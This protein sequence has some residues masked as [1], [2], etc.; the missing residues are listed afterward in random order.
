MLQSSFFDPVL[1]VDIHIVL[2]PTPAPV[3]T[4][5]PMPFIGMVFDPV[6]LAMGAAIGM[7]TGG[8]PGLVMVNS[9]PVTNAGTNVTN[10]L[11]MPH[12]PAPGVAF[13][14][15]LPGNDAE[16][17]FGS[18]DVKLAG[19]LGVRLGEIAM[20]CSDP[21]RLP[22][23]VVLA[24][25]KGMP[26]L[27][28]RPPVPDLEGIA[29]RLAMLGAMKLLKAAARGG[30]RLFR[31]LRTA[32]R[33][34]SKW[35]RISGAV[36]GV[37]DKIAPAR[38]RDRLKRAACFVTGHPV[39]VATGRVFTDSIDFGLPGSI[40]LVF[41]RVYSSSLSWRNGPLGYGWSHSL[42][43]QV[44]VEPNKVV[45]L[46]EDGR[47]VEFST[48]HLPDRVMRAGQAIFHPTERLTL[49][50]TGPFS[51]ALETD[52]G[53][54]REF[55]RVPGGPSRRAR[56]VR[57][58]NQTGDEVTWHYDEQGSLRTVRDCAGRRVGFEY[59][60]G[61]LVRVSVSSGAGQPWL[62]QRA[63]AYDGEGDLVEA[64]D[65]AGQSWRFEYV[66]HLL[67]REVNRNGLSFYFQY[68]GLG[69]AARCVRTW[70]DGGLLDRVIAYDVAN[71][72]TLVENSLGHVTVYE[73][74]DLGQVI[75]V[76]DALGQT[77]RYAYDPRTGQKC[78]EV[79]PL[80]AETLWEYDE[81]GH[82]TKRTRP[83]GIAVQMRFDSRGRLV[84]ARDPLEGEWSWAYDPKGRITQRVDP[85]GQRVRFEWDGSRL[86]GLHDAAGQYTR[87]EYDEQGNLT[88]LRTPDGTESLWRYDG[89]GQL[90]EG[91][92]AKGNV[93]KREYDLLGR[94]VRVCEPDGNVRILG[95]DPE[96]NITHVRDKHHEVLLAYQGL[97]RLRSRTES[98][99]TVSF[100]YDSEEQL[101]G[102][103]NEGG[104]AY[105]FEFDAA[106]AVKTER[107]F[108]G[109]V[110]QYVRDPA[111]R[112][113]KVLRPL[114]KVSEYA[115]DILG[116][117]TSVKHWDGI[118]TYR[119][120]ADGEF[121]EA[122][123][124]T[125]TVTFE[126]DALG[127]VTREQQG[128]DWVASEYDRLGRRVRVSSSKDFHQKIRRNAMGDVLELSVQFRESGVPADGPQ[129]HK[130]SAPGAGLESGQGFRVDF[131]RDELGF[132]LERMLPGGVRST[133]ERDRLGR[134]IRQEIWSPQGS[135]GARQYTWDVDD[136]L[137]M[138]VDS[139][140]GPMKYVHDS[141]GNLVAAVYSDGQTELRMP[142]A[143]GN[144][145]RTREQSDRRYGPT[146]QLLEA[147]GPRGVTRYEYD[148]EGNLVRKLEPD[149]REWRYEW[150]AS[151]MLVRV[152]RPDGQ[153][154]EFGYD[155]F[156]RRVWK[157]FQ[158]KTTR[159]I[160]DG[161]L[162]L[163]EWKEN[164]APGVSGLPAPTLRGV[165]DTVA[166]KRRQAELGE[167]PAQ[168]PP[169]EN[170][171][172]WVF[173]PGSFAPLAKFVDGE[174]FGIVTDHLGAPRAMFDG[175]GEKVWSAD[176]GVYGELLNL[177]GERDACPFRW[178]G[179]YEDAETGLYY[180]RHRYYAA[181]EGEYLSQDPLGLR[182]GLRLLGYVHDPCAWIDPLGFSGCATKG[183]PLDDGALVHR[184]GGAGVDNLHLK[185]PEKKLSPPGISL[186][187]ASSAEEAS[188]LAKKVAGE[189]GWSKMATA[190]E[191]MG[192]AKV[193]DIRAAGF[194]VIH[195][196]T[197]TWGEK[198][199][200][201]IHPDGA[202][203]FT[204]EN[205]DKLSK[206]FT[207]T[208]GL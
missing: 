24:I 22:T 58:S 63:F 95:Y 68:D 84:L 61:R 195:D 150:N 120:R 98:G 179:Q 33:N 59:E 206:V 39:D 6:G 86:T 65:S 134:P 57:Q 146:G 180:N 122:T 17:F 172:T 87:L 127:R 156:G 78:K 11:T 102:I 12:L 7:A 89:F 208:S 186:L 10:M 69:A 167:R 35:A 105:G 149:D 192:S 14:K 184:I 94:V 71:R 29:M 142:D 54:V 201:L 124:D 73:M 139:L 116:R 133:W 60:A 158:G 132:E 72:K 185:P 155:V 18:L 190:A 88:R 76:S 182:G 85:L 194:D 56:I 144:L 119:Y 117:V 104:F 13:A 90:Q 31:A 23:S 20:S 96:G 203:G 128:E 100:E 101:V 157:R 168:G 2:V 199:A 19:S 173:E 123:N 27:T 77:T 46:A 189:K 130:A 43:Q 178:P 30:A 44:W 115:Y 141:F 112:V 187:Q 174:C 8:G 181:E 164:P 66:G 165:A 154:V 36:R 74:D 21:V 53:L 25:P 166:A 143:V 200:R 41:E 136:R 196:C 103:K 188:A 91:V 191:T 151:G 47:E 109:L 32:Q 171:I 140:H 40:P 16:L 129:R 75:A 204:P 169:V 121:I 83:D 145:F 113:E 82:C 93:R 26:V 64:R 193:S 106:G 162:P 126:R 34:S 207:N 108:D 205:L 51:W 97:G 70:G 153:R 161:N 137:S 176:L 202:S 62:M 148:L 55:A 111:G 198:H 138:I 110:R 45:F 197:D 170:S 163:H 80:G 9:L 147:H 135:H 114:G 37:V 177:V 15:G 175:Q 125:A 28:I 52:E 152:I 1:G 118:E 4:P 50:C 99:T 3:P 5:V 159:W 81:R 160:W 107:G 79:D 38:L 183:Q 49:R 67:V 48:L 42:D 92:D 131:Q